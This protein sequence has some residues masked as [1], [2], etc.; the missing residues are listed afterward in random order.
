MDSQLPTLL[1]E[2]APINILTEPH[3]HET[4]T[5][6]LLSAELPPASQ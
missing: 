3:Y 6:M 2:G 4:H 1:E 5:E